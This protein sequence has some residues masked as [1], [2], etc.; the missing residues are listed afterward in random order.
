MRHEGNSGTM[1]RSPAYA[2]VPCA[3][4]RRHALAF[5]EA[6]PPE[7][8][9]PRLLD[10]VRA[11]A[12]LRHYS[13]RT[14][15]AYV[16]WTR[17]YIFFHGKRH[18]ELGAAEVTRFLSS[19]ASD[20]VKDAARRAGIAKRATPHTLR[21]SF[22][23]HLLE[24]GR[25]IRTVQELLGHRDVATTQIYAHVLNRGPSAVKSPI[26]TIFGP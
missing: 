12:R 23:T 1:H 18:P 24:D 2:T 22:A 6:S 19:L 11:A 4:G 26:D 25:D 13:R 10:R 17:R 8:A 7:P 20:V 21:H 14:V 3:S 9:K 15:A 5:H 16:A